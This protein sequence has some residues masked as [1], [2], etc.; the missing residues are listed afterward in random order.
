MNTTMLS[1][2]QLLTIALATVP[3]LI[4]VAIGILI[5]NHRLTDMKD[6]MSD[7]KETL[8]AEIK[9][10]DSAILSQMAIYQMDIISKIAELDNRITRL[11]RP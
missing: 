2:T 4:V 11:V 5:N 10:G 7:I 8:R 6:R 1:D 3:T 9:A